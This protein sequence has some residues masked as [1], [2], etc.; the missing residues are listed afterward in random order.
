MANPILDIS[1]KPK[2]DGPVIRID[3]L[4]YTMTGVENLQLRTQLELVHLSI[5]MGTIDP[6]NLDEK[7]LKAYGKAVENACLT[8]LPRLPREVLE[9]LGLLQMYK[10][11]GAY[12]QELKKDPLLQEGLRQGS[13]NS[14]EEDQTSG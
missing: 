3:G 4:D 5:Q 9:K 7:A 2:E 14:T 8:I 10:I 11:I 12:S 1:T 6:H 13:K